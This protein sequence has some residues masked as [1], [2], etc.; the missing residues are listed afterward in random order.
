[1]S[2]P[3]LGTRLGSAGDSTPLVLGP[4]WSCAQTRWEGSHSHLPSH[5]P[6]GLL[7]QRLI[8]A[9]AGNES[10]TFSS[11]P[12][13]AVGQVR[14]TFC[15]IHIIHLSSVK[16]GLQGLLWCR[17]LNSH[18]KKGA[19]L[20]KT[21][22]PGSAIMSCHALTEERPSTPG[23][24]KSSLFIPLCL[25]VPCWGCHDLLI[26]LRCFLEDLLPFNPKFCPSLLVNLPT[27]P[28]QGFLKIFC[29]HYSSLLI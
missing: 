20:W 18:R 9:L 29:Q 10:C 27:V 13:D 6:A 26:F 22:D 7:L 3:Y 28:L 4:G 25:E 8:P 21:W 24:E 17:T 15:W 14:Q 23:L 19:K 16:E 1:M 11:L 12:S 2:L 5:P